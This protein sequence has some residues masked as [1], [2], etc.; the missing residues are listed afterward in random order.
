MRFTTTLTSIF[1]AVS[2]IAATASAAENKHPDFSGQ[3]ELDVEKSEGLPPGLQQMMIV[4]QGGDRLEVELK[5]SGGP[6]GETTVTDTYIL[7]GEP[8]EFTPA[9]IGGKGTPKKGKRT[10]SWASDGRGMEVQEEAEVEGPEGPDT[11]KGKRTW[12]LSDDGKLLT[13]DIDLAGEQGAIKGKRI[14]HRK[15]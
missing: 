3:W 7:N 1:A 4:K 9:M 15:A 13:I 14:Y 2:I 12:R 5:L 8:A 11:V 10:S 6:S